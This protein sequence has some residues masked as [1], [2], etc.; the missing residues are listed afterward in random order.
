MWQ[1]IESIIFDE[2]QQ[3]GVSAELEWTKMQ[4]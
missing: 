3:A 1:I 4:I 2:T